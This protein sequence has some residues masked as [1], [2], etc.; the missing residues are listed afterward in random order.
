[1]PAELRELMRHA[2]IATTMAFYVGRN[3]Q[4]TAESLWA[5]YR[6]SKP[7][8]GNVLGNNSPHPSSCDGQ[9]TTQAV[10]SQR[11]AKYTSQ[12]SNL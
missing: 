4:T 2:D 11:L 7:A 8:A 5:A 1:M 3:A 6:D 9:E 12:D 10:D